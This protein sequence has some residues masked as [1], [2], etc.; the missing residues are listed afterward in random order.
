MECGSVLAD[1][2]RSIS[3]ICSELEDVDAFGWVI[4]VPADG[5]KEEGCRMS[6][7][8]DFLKESVLCF[9][10]FLASGVKNSHNPLFEY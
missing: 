8:E 3:C 10:F 5:V 6:R 2:V 1:Y 9:I 7:P 4:E